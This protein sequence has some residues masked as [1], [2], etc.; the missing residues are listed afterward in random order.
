MRWILTQTGTEIPAPPAPP[1]DYLN[2]LL[3][4]FYTLAHWVGQ[5]VVGILDNFLSLKTASDLIDPI[6]F[7]VLI[8]ALFI[9]AEIAK[10][11]TWLIVVAGWVLIVLKI[12]LDA[13]S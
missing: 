3:S 9:V 5:F 10:K 2:Q 7:L 4:F 13:T 12:V 11:I 6:G 1:E 8:T